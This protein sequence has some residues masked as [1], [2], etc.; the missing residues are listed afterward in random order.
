M[1]KLSALHD[2]S[3]TE[4]FVA[5]RILSSEPGVWKSKPAVLE[6]MFWPGLGVWSKEWS[7]TTEF[8]RFLRRLRLLVSVIASRDNGCKRN[9]LD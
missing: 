5:G 1:V 6:T 7:D 8:G 9:K 4:S 3:A 2:R